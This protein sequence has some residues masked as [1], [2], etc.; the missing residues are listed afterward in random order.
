MLVFPQLFYDRKL[1]YNNSF[2]IVRGFSSRLKQNILIPFSLIAVKLLPVTHPFPYLPFRSVF[3]LFPLFSHSLS[4]LCF[5]V[6][7]LI[8]LFTKHSFA[9]SPRLR[10]GGVLFTRLEI[11]Y[12]SPLSKFSPSSK[13]DHAIKTAGNFDSFFV[14]R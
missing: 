4:C 10:S 12:L 8:V 9:A 14:C 13:M 7:N 5:S 2:G 11:R 3:F 6:P 1:R